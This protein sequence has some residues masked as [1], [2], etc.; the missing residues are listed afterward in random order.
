MEGGT[1]NFMMPASRACIPRE[2]QQCLAG[3]TSG[4]RW[5][6]SASLDPDWAGNRKLPLWVFL[7]W[8]EQ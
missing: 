3:R 1:E 8:A 4:F 5:S 2:G 7:S 6:I